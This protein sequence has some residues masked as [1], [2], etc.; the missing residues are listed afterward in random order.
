MPV[1]MANQSRKTLRRTEDER[2]RSFF[3]N[4]TEA[5]YCIRFDRPIPVDSSVAEFIDS[6]YLYGYLDEV[7]DAYAKIAGLKSG[8]EMN[9]IRLATVMPRNVP[10][11]VQTIIDFKTNGMRG[12]NLETEEYYD[13]GEKRHLLNNV[14]G[15]IENGH[16]EQVWCVSQDVTEQKYLEADLMS[17]AGRLISNQENELRRLARELHDNLSQQLAVLAIEAGSLEDQADLPAAARDKI[18]SI[19]DHLID[20]STDV[21]RLS[22]N[23]HPSILDDLGLVKALQSECEN[24]SSRTGMPVVLNTREE[25]LVYPKNIAL[26]L[27]RIVQEG[28]SNAYRHSCAKNVYVFLEHD[29]Q[30]VQL[31][32]KDTGVGFNPAEVT[33]MTGLGL[34]SIR[35]RV[36]L[37]NGKYSLTTKTGKGAKACSVASGMTPKMPL[38]IGLAASGNGWTRRGGCK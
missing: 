28:L 36:R 4:S 14:S 32:I 15:V 27:Y 11:N 12:I 25:P 34:S 13:N 1:E 37:I 9:G 29:Q 3:E 30:N 19:K 33:N 24:F 21:H 10:E 26:N 8:R 6:A 20:I 31:S 23:L 18:L 17:L 2:L 38:I 5:I 16:L 35:E 7:N 22:R